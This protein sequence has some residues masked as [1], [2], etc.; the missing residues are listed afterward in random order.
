[1][2]IN[3]LIHYNYNNNNNNNNFYLLTL[4]FCIFRVYL[5]NMKYTKV[6]SKKV[7]LL[8]LLLLL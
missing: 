1:M 7:K 3:K 2:F 4:H 5:M 8:L 6:Q